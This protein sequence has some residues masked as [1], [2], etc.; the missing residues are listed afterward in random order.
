MVYSRRCR[1]SLYEK[2]EIER[3]MPCLWDESLVV[4][5]IGNPYAPPADMPKMTVNPS[6]TYTHVAHVADLRRAYQ[7]A[8]L[9]VGQK[10]VLLLRFG[11]D[12]LLAEIAGDL[13]VDEH[14]VRRRLD[15]GIGKMRASMNGRPSNRYEEDE[16]GTIA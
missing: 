13:S 12:S 15:S 3:L 6:H 5:G 4:Y 14:V 16:D 10:Q 8:G 2:A 11:L 1:L 7:T 9:S